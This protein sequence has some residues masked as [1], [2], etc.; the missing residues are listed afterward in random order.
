MSLEHSRQIEHIQRLGLLSAQQLE[1]VAARTRAGEPL[2]LSLQAAGCAP[3]VISQV[4]QALAPPSLAHTQPLYQAQPA[5][6]D[7]LA[8]GVSPARR[9][10]PTLSRMTKP[11]PDEEPEEAPAEPAQGPSPVDEFT[12][13]LLDITDRFELFEEIAHGA[14]GRIDAGWDR[15]LGRPVAIKTLRSDR[16]KDVVRMRFLE[17]AQVTGQLQHPNIITVYEL[18][19][20]RGEVVFVMRRVE[21]QSLKQL[22][23]RL[24]RDDDDM[25]KE[26]TLAHKLQVFFK[27]CQA[28]AFAH[29]R[30][31]IHR[32]IKPSNVMIG[33]FGDVVLLDWGLC[34]IIGQ[35][36]RSSRSSTERWQTM[37]GQIIGTPAYMSP[38]QALGMIDQVSPAT[39]VYGLGALLY[40]FITLHPPFMGKSNREVVRKVLQA[41]LTPPRERAPEL[42]I[43]EELERIC[44]KCLERSADQRYPSAA[45]LARD[46]Q[47]FLDGGLGE[48]GGAFEP[49]ISLEAQRAAL[50]EN[51]FYYQ[52]IQEDLASSHDTWQTLHLRAWLGGDE[53]LRREGWEA[54]SQIKHY[55][56]E[57]EA[58][59]AKMC[60]QLAHYQ[61]TRRHLEASGA[62]TPERPAQDNT[63]E[64]LCTLLASRYENAVVEGDD[65]AQA[66]IGQ[67]LQAFDPAQG[68]QLSQSVGALYIHVRPINAEIQLW[69]CVSESGRLKKTRP[70]T[71]KSSPLL[72]E[73]VPAGQYVLSAT[74]PGQSEAVESALR[75]YAGVTTR[76]S[77]T[78][79][80]REAA[81]PGFV[82]VPAGTFRSGAPNDPTSPAAEL[83]LPD[84]FLRKTP[85]TSQ[86]YLDFLAALA[87]RS[88]L[89]ARARQPRRSGDG[90]PL[91]RWSPA[92]A[93]L[94]PTEQGWSPETPVVGVSYDDAQAF[95]AWQSLRL[96]YA[97]RLP[98]ESEW[99]KAA[100]G[101][102]G[103]R[104]PWGE[105]WDPRFV[106]GPE[107]WD[108]HL[109]PPV[110]LM[111]ADT[112]CY[113][114]QDLVGGVRE[115]TTPSDPASTFG[116]LRGG[117]FLTD[118]VEGR[119]LWRKA[120]LA[121]SRVAPDVGFRLAL[122]PDPAF[123]ILEIL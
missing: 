83:A 65:R 5:R 39:D 63:T 14:M 106:A 60:E 70:K 122:S 54:L 103:R 12:G 81:P 72:L 25:V 76:L 98:T 59:I 61:W 32:D 43:P 121:T 118:A 8:R 67:W 57:S 105:A 74:L 120:L 56:Q 2:T 4:T 86:E 66:Q 90:A 21:G 84:V 44:L 102:D 95:C 71:L 13:V 51:L 87:E 6:Q 40:H 92:G 55:R 108:H 48:G 69:Q 79:Y 19:R 24:K 100:R 117:S 68:E 22:I 85:V 119:P 112:S 115:W 35:E 27:L 75:V 29:S 33:D 96:Q 28:V 47:A 89:E 16:A 78:L 77:V 73:K 93:P 82:H 3:L 107:V 64:L 30:G 116:V 20:L 15:H 46:V 36:V 38:E 53:Q 26:Y 31:V 123:R 113:G 58:L 109:P 18:G 11:D 88:P 49:L 110:G 50:E 52:E 1:L 10:L 7:A 41:E 62:L 17:E 101:M 111:S 104:F 37:H 34:K 99:E 91:W 114:V 42:R 9:A 97:V 45:E 94:L 23:Q 80:H